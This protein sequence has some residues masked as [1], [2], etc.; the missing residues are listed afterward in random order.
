MSTSGAPRPA[1][2]ATDRAA[3]RTPAAADGPD[4]RTTTARPPAPGD[5]R[6][7]VEAAGFVLDTPVTGPA[8]AA[9]RVLAHWQDGA[10]LHRLPDGRWLLTLSAPV[11]VRA[12]LAPGLPVRRTAGALVA[13]GTGPTDAPAGY[14]LLTT[15]G[16]IEA[17][18]IAELPTVDPAD[19]LDP[20]GLTV[21]R[22]GPVGTLPA[23]A[24]VVDAVPPPAAPDLRTAAGL[25]ARSATA[26]RL[27]DTTRKPRLRDRLPVIALPRPRLR[28]TADG[29]RFT[30]RGPSPKTPHRGAASRAGLWPPRGLGRL[31]RSALHGARTALRLL[32]NLAGAGLVLI[33][34][35]LILVRTVDGLA[36]GDIGSA[37]PLFGLVLL[38]VV[39]LAA[40]ARRQQTGGAGGGAAGTGRPGTAAG[41]AGRSAAGGRP[42]RP[43]L[44]GLLARLTLRSPAAALVRGRHAR[45]LYR[46]DRAFREKR[47]E[48]ALRD[49]I[50]LG[51]PG[52]DRQD[53]LSLGLPSRY[54][55][56]LRATPG[57]AVPGG[58]SALSGLDAQQYLTGLYRAAA[59]ALER[60]GRIDEAAFV[61]ADLLH[62]S[63]EAVAFLDRHGRTA[64]AAE[65]AEGRELDPD[66]VVRLWWRAGDRD[67]AV[68]TAHRRGAF[69]LA[70]ERLTA[71]DPAAARE[72]RLAWAQHC[73][74][75]GDRIGAVEA[76]WP[77]EELRGSVV[78]DLRD[79]VALG[80]PA[81]GRAL[82]HLLA[83]G[84][85]AATV[86]LARTVID[87]DERSGRGGRA[88]LLTT[89]SELPAADPVV[90]RELATAAA[91][92]AVRD[93]GFGTHAAQ[94]TDRAR[95]D[96][97][98]AR[99][100]PLT[101]ADLPRPVRPGRS[102]GRP[103][104]LTA[105][106]RPGTLPV[107]DAAYLHSGALLLA[108]G[109]AGVRLLTPDGRTKAR[110]D[111]PAD[112]LVL[113][114]HGGNAL[115]IADHGRVTEISR[116]DLATR[117]LRP[118]TTLR[119]TATLGTYDGRHLIGVDAHGIVVLDTAADRP[120][121]VWRELGGD[122]AQG[123]QRPAGP[124]SRTANRCS[125]IVLTRPRFGTGLTECWTWEL[126]GW[127]LT[128]RTAL[129]D[130]ELGSAG[131]FVGLAAL[132]GGGR[133]LTTADREAGRTTLRWF[134]VPTPGPFTVD[135]LPVAPPHTDGDDWALTVPVSGTGDLTVRAGR[136]PTDSPLLT[137]RVPAAPSGPDG[138]PT[139]VGVRRHATTATYWHRSG[140]ILALADDDTTVLANL[141]ITAD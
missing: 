25:G 20:G 55:G 50:Q 60:E 98:L 30:R 123:D 33:G 106:D 40:R 83:L 10:E 132:A 129:T 63:G 109:Q 100:D 93:G 13:V 133:L 59:E 88:A 140:R 5:F 131:T 124:P 105:A 116:L 92:A 44:R 48:D 11:T 8:E 113:A 128:S 37:S 15:R 47:W 108:C 89:L 135:G 82:A 7:T 95:F 66:L 3:A 112:R 117:T 76:V 71:T 85:P 74:S 17:H 36:S 125:A 2:P 4:P 130:D 87:S 28:R 122:N 101:A 118:W 56:A 126:P 72:L 67:R 110:W 114:D 91:R 45:Y 35:V 115:V 21:H 18:P 46:L 58:T 9:T 81:Q 43:L 49:A 14:L 34:L 26:D 61:L 23:P 27:L 51:A 103:L 111:T 6:G 24:P 90:D 32:V 39:A 80:G 42:R 94:G 54:T 136:R 57:V 78:A 22:L 53:W 137:L 120:T 19:W 69:P 16:R 97:L 31:L 121:V 1:R 29:P 70:V 104:E 99:A 62:R 77:E 73:R 65:L 84:A 119:S 102:G 96:R 38:L 41:A 141:R 12:D 107:L 86:Q 134:G 68:R 64:Q 52:G 79:A 127:R 139:P 138:R 75:A